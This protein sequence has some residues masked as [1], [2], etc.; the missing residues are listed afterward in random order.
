MKHM[1]LTA[2]F[3]AMMTLC[4]VFTGIGMTALAAEQGS[5]SAVSGLPEAFDLREQG[6]VSAVKDQGTYGTCWAHA[7]ISSLETN[8]IARTPDIDLSEWHLSHYRF[9]YYPQHEEDYLHAGS[10]YWEP[11]QMMMNQLGP[12]SEADC[13][14]GSGIPDLTLTDEEIRKGAVL[15]STDYFAYFSWQNDRYE[16]APEGVKQAIYSGHCVAFSL[17]RSYLATECYDRENHSYYCSSA[18]SP[19][20]DERLNGETINGHAMCIVGWD[21]NFPASAFHYTPP[22]DGAW[23]VKNSWGPTW[24]D[25]GYV[26]ISYAEDYVNN[27][28]YIETESAAAHDFFF[29]HDSG[30]L[31]AV[32]MNRNETDTEVHYAN[33]FYPEEDCCITD[34]ML[35]SVDPEDIMEVTLYTGLQDLNDP[36]SGTASSVT[37]VQLPHP[38][39]QTVPLQD[40]VPVRK[41]EPFSVTVRVSGRTG[42]KIPCEVVQD[43]MEIIKDKDGWFYGHCRGSSPTQAGPQFTFVEQLERDFSAHE[44]F[45]SADGKNWTDC[46]AVN[47]KNSFNSLLLKIGNVCVRAFGTEAGRVRFSDDHDKLPLG[48]MIT[49]SNA[50]NADIYY[51]VNGGEYALYTEPIEFTG[52]MTVSA[53]ADTGEKTVYTKHY[54]Q[55]HAV[56]SSLLADINGDISYANIAEN[57][58]C[59]ETENFIG[60]S[61]S[62]LPVSTGRIT[63]NGEPVV[64]GHRYQ[65]SREKCE[66]GIIIRV[67]QEGMI[68]AEYTVRIHDKT[69][70]PFTNGIYYFDYED[71]VWELR[72]GS[73]IAKYALTGETEEFTYENTGYG[74]WQ[75]TFA[76][77][78]EIWNRRMLGHDVYLW[79]E[80][81]ETRYGG[82]LSRLSLKSYPVLTPDEVK[83]AAPRVLEQLTGQTT[84]SVRLTIPVPGVYMLE[85]FRGETLI[86]T[87]YTNLFGYINLDEEQSYY[88]YPPQYRKCDFDGSGS[89][90]IADAVLM[91]RI[92]AEDA[93]ETLPSAEVFEAADLDLDGYLT[94]ADC[95]LLLDSLTR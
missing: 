22:M 85:Y 80:D 51:A 46:A 88:I 37:T 40:A 52:D 15:E 14:Y 30:Y 89:V 33:I 91:Q 81:G 90:S 70:E 2:G 27:F 65:F 31:G 26:W 17:Q 23:L 8:E 44:S 86:D 24:G 28:Y 21:D 29:S 63:I 50:E 47:V 53:Y 38:E 43:G 59:F 95:S 62:L 12:V 66:N 74:V 61:S 94:V 39:Y 75:F 68:P 84:D 7:M 76:D 1:R 18:H 10:F 78:T 57:E 5:E 92:L 49:L 25:G 20:L 13:P 69:N 11:V 36:T 54:T 77:R 16:Y 6:L 93:P 79:N 71:L 72:S 4:T 55:Q 58:I 67:E 9:Q 3:T 87:I 35:C 82:F 45:I 73:G 48:E 64:S 60:N 83:A 34:V 32:F 41:G 19:E 56:L 42:V